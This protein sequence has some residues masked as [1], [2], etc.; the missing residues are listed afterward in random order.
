MQD[1]DQQGIKYQ[2]EPVTFAGYD[3][4]FR[5][6]NRHNEVWLLA[7]ETDDDQVIRR[8]QPS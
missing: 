5:L 3:P 2:S 1:L 8:V 6:R 7:Q 4:P